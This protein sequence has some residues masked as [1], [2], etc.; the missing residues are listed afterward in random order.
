MAKR[1]KHAYLIVAHNQFEI[2]EM[3]LKLLDYENH[4]FLCIWMP[5]FL[6]LIL[7]ILNAYLKNLKLLL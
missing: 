5:M 3:L 2:L 7:T 1:L 4:D 6:I